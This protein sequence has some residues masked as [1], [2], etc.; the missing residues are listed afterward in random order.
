M[1]WGQIFGLTILIIIIVGFQWSKLKQD[2]KKEKVTFI[3]ISVVG[4][5]LSILLIIF[6][7]MIGPTQI[8]DTLF[9]PLGKF[10]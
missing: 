10:L 6:P 8:I 9:K 1:I 7:D 2:Q 3:S 5:I 4:W